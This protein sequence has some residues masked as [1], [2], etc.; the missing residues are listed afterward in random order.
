VLSKSDVTGEISYKRVVNTFIR[1]TDE[2][3]KLTFTNSSLLE[4]TWNHPFRRFKSNLPS[5]AFSIEN[6]EWTEARDL[7]KGDQVY[8][9]DG[10]L[11]VVESVVID[12]REETVYN[13]EVE[14]FHTYFVGEDG[15]WVHNQDCS[16]GLGA[17]GRYL[18]LDT[19][20]KLDCK[21]SK[22][23]LDAYR[24]ENKRIIKNHN[25][26]DA[27]AGSVMAGTAAGILGWPYIA[28]IGTAIG[29]GLKAEAIQIAAPLL[30]GIGY[31]LNIPSMV[32]AG[33]SLI[34]RL[35]NVTGQ[36]ITAISGA[37]GSGGKEGQNAEKLY[38]YVG[39][40]EAVAIKRSGKIPNVDRKGSL[41]DVYITDKD[42]KTAGKAKT[43]L[44]LPEKPAYKVVIDPKNVSN[45]T[46]LKKIN[47]TDNPQWGKGGGRQSITKEPIPI[48]PLKIEKLKGVE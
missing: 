44:Q 33:S 22:S 31:R 19:A 27:A 9:A 36:T 39:E 40:G 42:Y 15:V 13:F 35:P 5:D 46:P 24:E 14:D 16:G 45:S 30:V 26:A 7:K 3:Y 43:H 17:A 38:R 1:Q 12:Q 34:S 4:T 6:S 37:K 41:K 10:N 11:L 8:S 32:N 28:G 2:I 47:P 21:G 25:D 48:D 23:C 29:T 18:A 20:A